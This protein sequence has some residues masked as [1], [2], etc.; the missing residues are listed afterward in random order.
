MAGGKPLN[1]HL[2]GGI[3]SGF[4]HDGTGVSKPTCDI[5]LN[6]GIGLA[7]KRKIFMYGSEE[8]RE[9]IVFDACG[10]RV[11]FE[12]PIP[13]P[14]DSAEVARRWR[15]VVHR[16]KS[17]VIAVKEGIAEFEEEFLGSPRCYP[18]LL[19]VR[20]PERRNL[21]AEARQRVGEGVAAPDGASCHRRVQ[22]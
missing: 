15:G 8:G 17:K 7:K 3:N 14:D 1:I 2:R 12:L 9:M 21:E 19:A 10:R 16:V 20:N 4:T 6:P 5:G 13:N 11:R 18:A 22:G